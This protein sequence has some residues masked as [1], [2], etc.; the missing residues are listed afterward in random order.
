MNLFSLIIAGLFTVLSVAFVALLA[1]AI[2]RNLQ[3]GQRYRQAIARQLSKLRLARM[4]GIHHIDQDAYLH[5]QSVLSI[6]DQIKRCSECSSTEDCD[7]LLNEGMGDE[8][9]FCE[10][11]EA[12]R[13]VRDKLAP[14]P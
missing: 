13:K 8:S 1:L 9:D 6:R 3:V 11:D 10:N 2:T 4:L 5:A 7:R 12:L 14:A